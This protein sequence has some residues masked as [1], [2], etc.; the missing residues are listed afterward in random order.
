MRRILKIILVTF[1]IYVLLESWA[2]FRFDKRSV[3][4]PAK[5]RNNFGMTHLDACRLKPYFKEWSQSGVLYQTDKYGFRCGNQTQNDGD[6]LLLAGDSIA[7]GVGLN[8]EESISGHL[9]QELQNSMALRVLTQA[10]PGGCPSLTVEHLR[11]DNLIDR[12]PKPKWILHSINHYDTMDDYL[13]HLELENNKD[14]YKYVKKKTKITLGG[15]FITMLQKKLRS[16]FLRNPVFPSLHA[17]VRW[18]R[19][20]MEYS[21]KPIKKLNEICKENGIKLI[22]FGLPDKGETGFPGSEH[23]SPMQEFCEQEAIAF[24]DIEMELEKAKRQGTKLYLDD[25]IHFTSAG[26]HVIGNTLANK[27][28]SLYTSKY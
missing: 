24:L 18:S 16:F 13:Y 8:Y 10:L 26:S 4:Y 19:V 17:G 12:I 5:M 25:G 6:V 14:F 11:E 9:E 1:L 23:W 15:Y 2:Q 20:S 27:I 7:F 3:S 22:L 21:T 28:K